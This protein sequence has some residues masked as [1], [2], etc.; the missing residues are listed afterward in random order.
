[1]GSPSYDVILDVITR[2]KRAGG[3]DVLHAIAARL[4]ADPTDDPPTQTRK[5]FPLV[6][7]KDVTGTNDMV[8]MYQYEGY[9]PQKLESNFSKKNY[10]CFKVDTLKNTDPR[11]PAVQ[12]ITFSPSSAFNLNKLKFKDVKRQNCVDED[13]VDV[14]YS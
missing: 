5:L 7:G 3:N 12:P 8:L 10:R 4:Q 1:M 11:D 9:S 14:Y 2:N 6:L 13:Y